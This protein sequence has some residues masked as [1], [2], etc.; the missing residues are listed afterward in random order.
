MQGNLKLSYVGIEI[1]GKTILNVICKRILSLFFPACSQDESEELARWKRFSY[2]FEATSA[3]LLSKKAY[4]F[5]YAS[6]SFKYNCTCLCIQFYLL[7]TKTFQ[8]FKCTRCGLTFVAAPLSLMC[9][10]R[11]LEL[12]KFFLRHSI[13]YGFHFSNKFSF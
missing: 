13:S 2:F 7:M 9:M 4:P 8:C 5:F 6:L 12:V 1:S 10:F 11:K 3:V